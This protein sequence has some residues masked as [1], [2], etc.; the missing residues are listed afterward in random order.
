MKSTGQKKSIVGLK[1][2]RN[3]IEVYIQKIRKGESF[4]IVRRSQPVFRV[5]PPEEDENL[6]ETVVDF[7]KIKKGGVHIDDLISR[8]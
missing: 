2:L 5:S 3:N 1:E 7:T 8:L 6:W 4:T